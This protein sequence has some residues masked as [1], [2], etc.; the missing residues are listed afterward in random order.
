MI[1]CMLESAIG[2]HASAHLVARSGAFSYV[3]LDGNRLLAEDVIPTVEGPIH[4]I[5]GP[6]HGITPDLEI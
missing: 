4:D 3:D 5:S 2:I 6:G 1:G